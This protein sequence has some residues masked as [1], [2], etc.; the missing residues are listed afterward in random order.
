MKKR[1]DVELD[2]KVLAWYSAEATRLNMS[3]RQ[4]MTRVMEKVQ[5]VMEQSPNTPLK[6]VIPTSLE[7]KLDQ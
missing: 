1:V 7:S 4:Y 3:R 2:L 6:Y 5:S